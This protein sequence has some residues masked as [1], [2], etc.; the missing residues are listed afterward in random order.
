MIEMQT[1]VK[2]VNPRPEDPW[3]HGEYATVLDVIW[4]L[5]GSDPPTYIVEAEGSDLWE[6][7]EDQMEKAG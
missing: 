2:L 4:P 3:V 5:A 6:V 1:E 7:D